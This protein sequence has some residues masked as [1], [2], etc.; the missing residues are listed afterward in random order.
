MK[1][2]S[3]VNPYK[4]DIFIP[5][6]TYF[7]KER[8]YFFKTHGISPFLNDQEGPTSPLLSC[9]GQCLFLAFEEIIYLLKTNVSLFFNDMFLHKEDETFLNISMRSSKWSSWDAPNMGYHKIPISFSS[10]W[11]FSQHRCQT[12]HNHRV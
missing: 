1:Q 10:Q 6:I 4:A 3:R 2:W 11:E 12:I 8:S 7:S 9:L 5:N